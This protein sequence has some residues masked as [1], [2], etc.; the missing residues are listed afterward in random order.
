MFSKGWTWSSTSQ[1][2]MSQRATTRTSHGNKRHFFAAFAIRIADADNANRICT[3]IKELNSNSNELNWMMYKQMRVMRHGRLAR[4]QSH[5][6]NPFREFIKH[7]GNYSNQIPLQQRVR[8]ERIGHANHLAQLVAIN[9]LHYPRY[10]NELMIMII[11]WYTQ[12]DTGTTPITATTTTQQRDR[13][14]SPCNWL[15]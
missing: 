3:M 6:P 14:V 13:F 9:A 5:V 1:S 8:L 12:Q 7:N 4:A 10:S 11:K 15:R 2:S